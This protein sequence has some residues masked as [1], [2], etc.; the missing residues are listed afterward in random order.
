VV[1]KHLSLELL[2]TP[3]IRACGADW[4]GSLNGGISV[5][6]AVAAAVVVNLTSDILQVTPSLASNVRRIAIS[7]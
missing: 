7:I 3:A 5:P 1:T 4:G 2:R 6:T